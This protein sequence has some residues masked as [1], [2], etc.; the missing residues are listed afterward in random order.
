MEFKDGGSLNSCVICGRPPVDGYIDVNVPGVNLLD[1]ICRGCAEMIAKCYNKKF[2]PK[3]PKC[4]CPECGK[5]C[6]NEGALF[7]H[8]KVHRNKTNKE[9]EKE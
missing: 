9:D 2:P 8:M 3:A 5:V 4:V 1:I 7:N 6:A